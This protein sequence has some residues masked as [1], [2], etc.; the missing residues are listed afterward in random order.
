MTEKLLK[1]SMADRRGFAQLPSWGAKSL[2]GF[3][4]WRF[5]IRGFLCR[6]PW[7]RA[8]LP[9]VEKIALQPANKDKNLRDLTFSFKDPIVSHIITV[10]PE[11]WETSDCNTTRLLHLLSENVYQCLEIL[12]EGSAETMLQNLEGIGP[13]RGLEAWARLHRDH[14]GE[15]GPRRVN[16]LDQIFH[17][18]Q[19]SLADV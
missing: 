3:A 13:C 4:G 14:Y 8:L 16:L 2:E 9:V 5:K 1:E 12:L 17:P 7:F 6:E 19:V 15:S 11:E 10:E 18:P